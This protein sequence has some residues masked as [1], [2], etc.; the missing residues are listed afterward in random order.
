M[1]PHAG[2]ESTDDGQNKAM[3]PEA[4]EQEP[5][6]GLTTRTDHAFVPR[7]AWTASVEDELRNG[8]WTT[9]HRS[10]G[11]ATIYCASSLV[12]SSREWLGAGAQQREPEEA[13]IAQPLR[14]SSTLSSAG[15]CLSRFVVPLPSRAILTVVISSVFLPETE[16]LRFSSRWCRSGCRTNGH[17]RGEH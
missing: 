14:L 7:S 3:P 10:V 16:R 8:E 12:R 9:P 1:S 6:S 2:G 4:G 17:R 5:A 13:L 15:W 11:S